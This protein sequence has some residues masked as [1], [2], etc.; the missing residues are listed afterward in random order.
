LDGTVNPRK[1]DTLSR[2]SN[3][4]DKSRKRAPVTIHINEYLS[5]K[6][7]L[8]INSRMIR[9]R[10]IDPIMANKLTLELII[11]PS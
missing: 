8:R 11:F 10:M 5:R 6:Y 7:F 4:M 2:I 9:R 1:L 3:L